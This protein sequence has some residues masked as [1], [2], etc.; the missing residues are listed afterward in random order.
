MG[1]KKNAYRILVGKPEISRKIKTFWWM[2]LKWILE[3]YNGVLWTE[4]VWLRIE[5]SGGSCEYSNELSGYII[6][7]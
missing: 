1:S 6:Y 2:I 5:T 4:F 7:C 3:K